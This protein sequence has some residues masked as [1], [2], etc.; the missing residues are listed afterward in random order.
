MGRRR[1]GRRT[2]AARYLVG[3][4]VIAAW[5]A[6]TIVLAR[7][8]GT[9]SAAIAGVLFTVP[10]CSLGEWFVHGVLYHGHLPGLGFIRTIHHQG[11]HF[12]LFPPERYVQ[13]TSKYEFMRFRK[14]L[15]PFR[16]SDNAV[17]NFLTKWSQIG[18]HFVTGIPLIMAPAWLLTGSVAFTVSSLV[19]LSLISWGLAYVHGV[20]HTPGDRWVERQRW[21]QWLDR[22]HYVHHVDLQANMNFGLP[23]C[24]FLFGTQ[25]WD[26]TEKEASKN[27]SFEEAKPM[28]KDVAPKP[29]AAAAE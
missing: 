1:S 27:P 18:L 6:G 12:A 13:T 20:I 10:L 16:M 3:L 26:M 2:S 7:V 8:G 15:V 21:F 4:G 11:H 28:A 19:A 24:D 17:D 22:H 9:A 14:P 29:M 25:K 5:S 23:L